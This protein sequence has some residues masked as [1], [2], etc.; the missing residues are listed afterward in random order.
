MRR[1]TL[2]TTL[3]ALD[4]DDPVVTGL[5]DREA[6]RQNATLN[7]IAAESTASA[8]VLRALGSVFN[9]K[10]AE[11]YP[12]RRYHRGCDIAD[13]LEVLAVE[14]AKLLFGSQHANV[15]VHSGVQANVAVYAAILKPGDPVVSMSLRH[16]GHLSHGATASMTGLLY[17]F[18]QYGV[19]ADTEQIDYDEVRDLAREHE[20]RMI[21][22]G[23]SSY[24]RLIDY[25]LLRSIADEVGA[26]LLVDMS[27][28][29]GLVASGVIPSPIPHAQ[30]VTTTTYKSLLGPHGGVVLC[31]SDHAAAVDRAVFPATQGTPSMG[32]IAAKAVCFAFAQTDEFHAIQQAIVANAAV[33]GSVLVDGGYRPVSGGTDNHLVLVDLRPKGLTGDV[34]EVALEAVGIL[35]NRNAIPFDTAPIRVTS[36]L[37]FGTPGTSLRGM[38]EQEMRRIGAL[39][40]ETLDGIGDESV[41]ASVRAEVSELAARFPLPGWAA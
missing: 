36:G 19:R 2:V 1:S 27:H 32:Q 33:L 22:A 28:V 9:N 18:K 4:Y 39:I 13:E 40:V 7:M 20:P 12:G 23:G 8:A 11:G 3:P 35:C 14:R 16:G 10:P 38:G 41:A 29:S 5:I 6:S 17:D 31:G 25:A 24:P 15:Q 37:R 26:H 21:V 30:F 34:A